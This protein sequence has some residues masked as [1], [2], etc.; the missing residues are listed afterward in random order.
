VL[1]REKFFAKLRFGENPAISPALNP[2]PILRLRENQN[3]STQVKGK[4]WALTYS[5]FVKQVDDAPCPTILWNSRVIN[6]L[7]KPSSDQRFISP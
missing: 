6:P 3:L 1:I 5:L 7:E 4:I 2:V